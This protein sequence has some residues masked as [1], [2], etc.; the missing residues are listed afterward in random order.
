MITT[1]HPALVKCNPESIIWRYIDLD[2]FELLLNE[3]ALFLCR[4]DK[5]SDPFE[6]SIPKREADNR[7]NEFLKNSV[8]LSNPMTIEEAVG[9]SNEMADFHKRFRKTFIVNCWH[10][11]TNE[12]DAMWRLYLKTNEGVAIQSCYNRLYDSLKHNTEEIFV[13]KVRYLDY[14]KD[15]WG[16][17]TDYPLKGYNIFSPIV[18]KRVEFTHENELRVFQHVNDAGDNSSYWDDK[19]NRIGRNI[20]CDTEIL[21]DKIILPPTSEKD[22]LNKVENL[23]TKYGLSKEIAKSKLNEPPI[24]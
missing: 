11:S 18:H 1:D 13:S 10:I 6:A 22:V 5:F 15:I 19:P 3:R 4:S 20:S 12:S 7:V 9:K 2:K 16:H 8:Q 21:I 17:E 24:Y 14:D 23:L